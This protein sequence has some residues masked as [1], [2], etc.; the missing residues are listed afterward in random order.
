MVEPQGQGDDHGDDGLH[1]SVHTDHHWAQ[2]LLADRNQEI[3]D[4]GGADH[5]EQDLPENVHRDGG[6]V[7]SP[8][9]AESERKCQERGEQ[10]HPFHECHHG[11]LLDERLEDAHVGGEAQ[12]VDHHPQDA[13]DGRGI[14]PGT[15]GHA[16]EDK[17][18]HADEAERDAGH[19]AP[20]DPFLDDDGRYDERHDGTERAHD[21]RVDG[22]AFCDGEQKRQLR[23]EQPQERSDSH[24]PEVFPIDLLLRRREQR[25]DPEQRR[26]PERPQAEQRHRRN[27]PVDGYVLAT[28][29]V[30]PE[31][32][33]GRKACQV[34]GEGT[35]ILVGSAIHSE[36]KRIV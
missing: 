25:P 10:E 11:I 22:R 24:L 18:H 14:G 1:I 29:D 30:E 4:E 8:E 35:V 2:A 27:V 23:H 32:R 31:N 17:D 9:S 13:P 20:G 15:D 33:I 34:A 16:I 36:L 5:H 19:A 28:D 7:R 3:S 21:G 6:Q 12:C 26:R